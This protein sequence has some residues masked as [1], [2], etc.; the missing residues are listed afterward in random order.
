MMNLET[1]LNKPSKPI[2]KWLA[3]IFALFSFV[4]FLDAT[5]LA[6]KHYLGTPVSCSI[7]AGCEKVTT[8]QY[9]TLWGVPVALFGA[10]YYLFI[11]VLVVAY[12]DT[13]KEQVLYFVARL[14]AIGF[15]ASIWFLYL[16]LFVIKAICFYCVVSFIASAVLLILGI[17]LLRLKIHTN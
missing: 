14:T 9:A 2:N 13:K 7:F 12:L 17:V 8:S 16:Q 5:Y 6:V 4:G 3:W 11:F 1:S 10:I 15:L